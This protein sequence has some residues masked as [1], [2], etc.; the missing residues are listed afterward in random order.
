MRKGTR[1]MRPRSAKKQVKDRRWAKKNP[2]EA[3]KWERKNGF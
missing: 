2:V 3:A 1:R